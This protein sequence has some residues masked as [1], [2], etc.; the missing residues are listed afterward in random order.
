[1]QIN[2]WLHIKH[3]LGNPPSLRLFQKKNDQKNFL[4]KHQATELFDG[5]QNIFCFEFPN[6]LEKCGEEEEGK[7]RIHKV[8]CYS[9]KR[10]K[11][12]KMDMQNLISL[13]VKKISISMNSLKVVGK[14][15]NQKPNQ[16]QVQTEE[17][18]EMH[19][20]NLTLHKFYKLTCN[21]NQQ[22]AGKPF[23]PITKSLKTSLCIS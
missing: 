6:I 16:N 21:L 11:Q 15:Q 18:Q 13:L 1:M 22:I 20:M 7:R 4:L 17:D 5:L 12:I 3:C 9:G 14:P 19:N 23:S 8:L 10:K 2:R